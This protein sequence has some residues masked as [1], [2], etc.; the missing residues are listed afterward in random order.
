[1]KKVLSCIA[2]LLSV[3]SLQS[4]NLVEEALRINTLTDGREEAIAKFNADYLT[5][6]RGSSLLDTPHILYPDS[7][8][9]G[10]NTLN[11]NILPLAFGFVPDSVRADVIGNVIKTIRSRKYRADVCPEVEPYVLKT[12]YSIGH[13]EMAYFICEEHPEMQTADCIAKQY[14]DEW[15]EQCVAG[16]TTVDKRR[17]KIRIRPDFTIQE[18]DTLSMKVS[19]P[20][21]EVTSSFEKD[22]MHAEWH[23]SIPKGVK[24]EIYTPTVHRRNVRKRCLARRLRVEDGWSVWKVRGGEHHFSIDFDMP[25]HVVE[26]QF[27]YKNEDFPQCH[28]N[29]LCFAE[30]GDLLCAF[31]GGTGEHYP[32]TK[33]RIARKNKG[34][35]N[36][37]RPVVVAEP[38]KDNFCLDNPVL[39][40]IPEPG[41]PVRLWYKI[42]P[43]WK[44]QEGEID[45]CS[46][47]FWEGRLK[48]STDNGYTWSEMQTLPDGY[49]GP[50][51]DKPVYHKGRLIC[52]SSR[53][54]K[55]EHLSRTI[56]FEW[57]DDKGQSWNCSEPEGVD[58]SIPTK[59]RVPGR[60]GENVDNPANPN[61]YYGV[62][63]PIS[64]IQPTIFIHKDGS[65]QALCR[66]GN[67]KMG[68][69]WS[70]DNGQT[71]SRLTLTDMPQNNSGID[72]TT[73]P[74]GRFVLV[75]NK[76][77]SLPGTSGSPRTPLMVAVSED[78][79]NWTD[80]VTLEDDAIKEYSYPAVICDEQGYV[81]IAY[82][83]RRYRSKYVKLKL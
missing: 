58:L 35:D 82:T 79:R 65:L 1:M 80:V 31:Y 44:L 76:F 5:V 34:T 33:V 57:S 28:S 9:Y 50:I 32:D 46:I 75:Y 69:T 15:M 26:R 68:E 23:F 39:F 73:L 18:L 13:N 67:S 14:R 54:P 40:R 43:A 64:A 49:L 12:L 37:S 45:L 83:W 2:A 62:Y 30:N 4:R 10:S 59:K 8:F 19:T 55:Y 72:G 71:W 3:L 52:P 47:A 21:G 53:E 20:Y 6:R 56:H 81:H 63:R 61:D 17:I 22:L 27:V 36:W 16:I 11:D 78:G 24:A 74:D 29:T 41:E 70:R 42:R 51:K 7:T 66:T 38:D 25:E 48:T 60:V 77:E